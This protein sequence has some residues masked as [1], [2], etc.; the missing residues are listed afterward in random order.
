MEHDEKLKQLLVNIV[1]TVRHA[2]EDAAPYRDDPAEDKL[3]NVY[4]MLKQLRREQDNA[5]LDPILEYIRE[6]K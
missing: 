2:W 5:A 6:G 4:M 3:A 1:S